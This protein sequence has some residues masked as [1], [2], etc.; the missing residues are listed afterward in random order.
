VL[1]PQLQVQLQVLVQAASVLE[2][3]H[4]N[5]RLVFLQL[6]MHV[7]DMSLQLVLWLVQQLLLLLLV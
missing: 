7:L 1:A 2:H 5:R 4:P 3:H 6:E